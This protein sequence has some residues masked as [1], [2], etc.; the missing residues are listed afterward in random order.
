[1]FRLAPHFLKKYVHNGYLGVVQPLIN[2]AN[3]L[4]IWY[5]SHTAF[6]HHL[7]KNMSVDRTGPVYKYF[8]LMNTH[9]PQVVDGRCNY[10]GKTRPRNRETV[11]TQSRCSLDTV[12]KVLKKLKDLGIYDDALIILMAD[13]GA[14]IDPYNLKPTVSGDRH[15]ATAIRPLVVSMATPLMAIKPPGGSGPLQVSRPRHPSSTRLPPS[16]P[17]LGWARHFTGRSF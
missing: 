7:A 9:W 5:F 17:C 14:G 15:S 11:T 3:F 8:H 10:V 13:H 2:D 4:K 16:T 1:M 12:I 6:L